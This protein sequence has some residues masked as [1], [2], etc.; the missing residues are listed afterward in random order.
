M[1]IGD[2]YITSDQVKGWISLDPGETKWDVIIE[3]VVTSISRDIE[4][5]C[6]RQFND[7]GAVSP[8]IY[9]A[10]DRECVLV[11]DFWTTEGFILQ[12]D[13][14]NDGVFETTWDST[15]YELTPLN[16]I[17]NGQLG[18]PY[19]C[20]TRRHNSQ[21]RF[22]FSNVAQVQVTAQWGWENVPDSVIQA[23]K[24]MAAD[25]FQL[26]DA[27]LGVAG[28]DQFGSVVRVKDSG[29]ACKRLKNYVVRSALV[30]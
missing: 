12:S 22:H 6:H 15:E 30:A 2:N 20:I 23:A 8:R 29:M 28:S 11:D 13:D 24:I 10:L 19:W 5:Y 16:G 7:S 26:K 4:D 17:R 18:W 9:K 14:D 25:T 27:R 21:H 3:D 1:A